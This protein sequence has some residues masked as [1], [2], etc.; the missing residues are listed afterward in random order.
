MRQSQGTEAAE[1]RAGCQSMG[2]WFWF[3]FTD[4]TPIPHRP[5]TTSYTVPTTRHKPVIQCNGT[6]AL[7][8]PE[9]S[10]TSAVHESNTRL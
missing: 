2:S 10:C 6:A 9:A 5:Y 4:H 8:D 3:N 7:L 1:L